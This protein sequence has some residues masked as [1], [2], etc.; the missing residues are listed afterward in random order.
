MAEPI[1]D[2][3]RIKL[4]AETMEAQNLAAITEAVSDNQEAILKGIELLATLNESGL[5]DAV[6]ALL[7]HRKDAMENIVGELNKPQYASTLENMSDLFFLLGDLKMDQLAYFTE[8]INAG[9]NEARVSEKEEPISYMGLLK[10]L[11]NPEVN[12]SITML[13]GFLRG[14][15]R[16]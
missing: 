10:T 2:I 11:K 3:N 7:K 6:N 16:E 4:S 12:R 15:G 1:K 14:M 13:L 8:K 5:L 9:M